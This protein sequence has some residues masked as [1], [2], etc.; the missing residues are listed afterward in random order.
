VPRRSRLSRRT[1]GWNIPAV[2]AYAYKAS[3]PAVRRRR[4]LVGP[5]HFIVSAACPSGRAGVE[6]PF[7]PVRVAEALA[8]HIASASHDVIETGGHGREHSLEMQCRSS[9][10]AADVRSCRC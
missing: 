7:G 8:E 6:T 3:A 4:V 10:A 9:A 2:G 1:A 5:S